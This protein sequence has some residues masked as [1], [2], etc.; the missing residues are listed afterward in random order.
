MD[1]GSVKAANRR[2]AVRRLDF[3]VSSAKARSTPCAAPKRFR[4]ARK[5]TL[6]PMVMSVVCIPGQ[7]LY[8]AMRRALLS[9]CVMP[10]NTTSLSKE[11]LLRNYSECN[12]CV[13][14]HFRSVSDIRKSVAGFDRSLWL[15]SFRKNHH[16]GT[17][18]NHRVAE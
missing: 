11:L 14:S 12:S 18:R 7:I 2:F 6:G 1:M 15:R 13:Q 3:V 5:P 9:D 17:E 4:M 16:R 8:A 10:A